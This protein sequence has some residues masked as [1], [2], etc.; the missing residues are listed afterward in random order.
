MRKLTLRFDDPKNNEERY[1]KQIAELNQ[2]LVWWGLLDTQFASSTTF[3]NQTLDAVHLFQQKR[4]ITS[5]GVVGKNTWAEL[6]KSSNTILTDNDIVEIHKQCDEN[7]CSINVHEQEDLK[8]GY[9]L[10]KY[11]ESLKLTVYRCPAG[12]L[13]NGYGATRTL[14]GE[15]WVIGQKITKQMAEDLLRIQVEK[16]YLP[17]LRKIPYWSEMT[18]NQ[19]SALL[20]FAYNLGANFYGNTGFETITRNLKNKEWTSVPK[21]LMLYVNPGSSFEKGLRNRRQT[22]GQLWSK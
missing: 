3:S 1:K 15:P 10:I 2:R 13:T 5:D 22:E 8:K 7:G 6:T 17:Q 12:V 16:E 11:W 14:D 21:T 18:N 9:D 4:N 19:R 20:S